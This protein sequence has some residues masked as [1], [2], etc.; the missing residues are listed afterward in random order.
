MIMVQDLQ[1][2]ENA[3]KNLLYIA[4]LNKAQDSGVLKKIIGTVDAARKIGLMADAEIVEDIS[5]TGWIAVFKLIVN[6]KVDII[7]L[8]SCGILVLLKLLLMCLH[9]FKFLC[10][11][12]AQEREL[13]IKY[14]FLSF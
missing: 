10:L 1:A 3:G 4:Q 9:L 7:I 11:S 2:H 6:A 14:S 5:Y 8:R 13:I 12:R